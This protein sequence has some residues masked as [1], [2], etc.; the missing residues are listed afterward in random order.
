VLSLFPQ[1][2]PLVAGILQTEDR[3]TDKS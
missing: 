2:M 1:S 3:L